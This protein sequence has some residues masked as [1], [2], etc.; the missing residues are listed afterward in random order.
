M[1]FQNLMSSLIFFISLVL[2]LIIYN[3]I[4]I[5]HILSLSILGF[6]Y[7]SITLVCVFGILSP[8]NE[9]EVTTIDGW[10]PAF[11]FIVHPIS[12][13]FTHGSLLRVNSPSHKI[14]S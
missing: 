1:R 2:V 8:E 14:F 12:C 4:F 5:S 3:H 11:L 10:I 9:N 13:L 7:L 6:S